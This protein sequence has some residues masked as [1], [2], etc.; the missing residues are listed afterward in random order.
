[1]IDKSPRHPL[2]FPRLLPPPRSPVPDADSLPILHAL[3]RLAAGRSLTSH[4]AGAAFDVVMRGAAAPS[5]IAALLTGLRV[6]GETA[7]E[8]AGAAAALRRA[9]TS[10]SLEDSENHVDTCGTGGGQAGTF[11]ISTGVFI[12]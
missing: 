11:N 8:V 10:V 9:M 6:K 5:Q 2:R 4:E 3:D 7:D 12:E 1:L